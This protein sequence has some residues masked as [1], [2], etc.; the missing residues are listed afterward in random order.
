M[1]NLKDLNLSNYCIT[2]DGEVYSLLSS[3]FLK[4]YVGSIASGGEYYKVHLVSDSGKHVTK[5]VHRLVAETYI[6]ND[7]DNKTQVNHIDGNKLNNSVR[8]LEW[9]SPKENSLHSMEN[10]LRDPRNRNEKI[11]LIN[12]EDII[13]PK[14]DS[15]KKVYNS[16]DVHLICNM[17]QDGYRI[18]DVARVTGFHRKEIQDIR[19][20]EYEG[21]S[22]IIQ[23]YNF[24]HLPKFNKTD[25]NVVLDICKQLSEGCGINEVARSLSVD[26]KVVSNIY[27]RKNYKKLSSNFVW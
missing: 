2:K 15:G 12:K 11:K 10:N 26:R 14:R 22:D 20:N 5:K 3:K 17:L 1:K 21:Y 8:N 23:T 9:V 6:P 19:N 25:V 27:N 18:C 13:N 7:D 24:D 4:K 16:D